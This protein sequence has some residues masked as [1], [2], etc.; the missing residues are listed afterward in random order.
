MKRILAILTF[1]ILLG[2]EK[3]PKD[4]NFKID[5]SPLSHAELGFELDEPNTILNDL[6]KGEL[7]KSI[8]SVLL[9]MYGNTKRKWEFEYIGNTD[10]ISEM[11]FY[12]PHYKNCEQN[13]FD[14][15]YN[16][17]NVID[18]IISTRK[19]FCHEYEV[20]K[21]Y[22]FNYNSNGLLK[23][24]YM[25]NDFFVEEN[26][27]AYYPNGRI[28]EIYSDHRGR[29]DEPRFRVQKF[30]YDNSF[31]N[32]VKLEVTDGV[33]P[34]YTYKY[35]YDEKVNPFKDVFIAAS[36]FMPFIG[37]AYLSEN[38]VTTVIEKNEKNVHNLEFT[39][40]FIFNY[41]DTNSLIEYYFT[42]N[43]RVYSIN[44]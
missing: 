22:T 1:L 3:E 28:K 20:I 24:I 19:N 12:L 14:F 4:D 31:K 35:S 32:V 39:T 40:E 5:N 38:N 42:D 21:T 11:I 10:I 37:P 41:S 27:F 2:C 30:Q 7:N 13:T 18:T 16:E 17:Q 23:S 43:E 26:Y 33:E 44:Q 9:V 36:V 6:A 8:T 29:G 15:S 34:L 25:D